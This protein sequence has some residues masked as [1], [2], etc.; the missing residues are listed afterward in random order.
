MCT[1]EEEAAGLRPGAR[2]GAAFS[3]PS[4]SEFARNS[5]NTSLN[6]PSIGPAF[7]LRA[8]HG[9]MGSDGGIRLLI[10]TI[11]SR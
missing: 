4:T 2:A 11:S 5:E 7:A 8:N 10:H 9:G 3:N 6:R 1:D